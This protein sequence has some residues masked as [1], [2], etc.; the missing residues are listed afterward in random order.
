MANRR[1]HL[2][3]TPNVQP[4]AADYLDVFSGFTRRF[5]EL[6][7][8]LGY[9]VFL[10]GGQSTDAP[11]KELVT[12]ISDAERT[13]FLGE[14]PAHTV[15][16]DGSNPMFVHFNVRAAAGIQARKEP[17]DILCT[18]AG[19]AQA[20]VWAQHQELFFLEYSIG[21]RG[22]CAPY[23]IFQSHA[24]RHVAHGYTGMEYG[25][26]GDDVVYHWF[27]EDE[28]STR[29]VEDYVL[30]VGRLTS[31]KGLKT[32]CRAAEAAG[33]KLYLIGDGD[34]SLITYGEYLGH[35]PPSERNRWMA[36]ARLL[37]CPT[38]Y[39]EPSA[40]V[41]TEAQLCGTPVLASP[42]GG[43][44]E[45]IEDKATGLLCKSLE[46]FTEA[47]RLWDAFDRSYIRRRARRLYGWHAGRE[48]YGD[49]FS[50]VLPEMPAAMTPMVEEQIWP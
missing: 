3:S 17:G 37:L 23:R 11:C 15:W 9:D 22:V 19:T 30:Y 16:Y 34:P 43:F 38:E 1:V 32:V 50:R 25:R 48:A 31:V 12:C 45:Y 26:A 29:P 24:W 5:S 39:I 35:M 2:L 36:G 8:E 46:Q 14:A 7:T 27:H 10:Y 41:V 6:L 4:V 20:A 40:C 42:W 21:Y 47:I 28:F 13:K 33:V 44:T 49:Y 18:I